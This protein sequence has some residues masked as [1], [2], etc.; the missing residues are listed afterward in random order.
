[1]GFL[2]FPHTTRLFVP[3]VNCLSNHDAFVCM[4]SCAIDQT[5]RTGCSIDSLVAHC[6]AAS[7]PFSMSFIRHSMPPAMVRLSG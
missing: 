7:D 2:G 5:A 6:S 1:M 4:L 3:M